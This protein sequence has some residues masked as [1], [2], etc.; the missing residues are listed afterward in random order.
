MK[1]FFIDTEIEFYE[2]VLK[3]INEGENESIVCLI[4]DIF[5]MVPNA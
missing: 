1:R 5:N 3:Q 4:E 2:T